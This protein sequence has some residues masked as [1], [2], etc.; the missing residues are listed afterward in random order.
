VDFRVYPES[1]L[2]KLPRYLQVPAVLLRNFRDLVVEPL[3]MKGLYGFTYHNDGMATTH[4]SPFVDDAKFERAYAEMAKWWWQDRVLD[5]RWRMWILTQAARQCRALPG[6]FAE[7]GVYRGGCAFMIL[8]LAD[9]NPDQRYFLF[10]TFEGIPSSN[11]TE[12]EEAAGFAGR[13]GDT[14]VAHVANVLS[15]W[16]DHLEFVRGDIF[17]TLEALETG[18]IAFCHLDLNASAPTIRALEYVYPRL[19]PSAM[20]VMDDYT[21]FAYSEQRKA[22]DE[23]VR[24]K[25]E[26]VLALPT[27]QGLLV[28]T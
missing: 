18:P 7:F 13:L 26:V 4:Y 9:L 15:P 24:D 23:F 16:T 3:V 27:G 20:I 6:H 14:T 1:R 10:D 12:S 2:G 19:L 21:Q 28:K 8:T 17:D 11:L 25:P 22:I 5:V